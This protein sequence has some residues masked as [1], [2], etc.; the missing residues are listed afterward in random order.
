MAD[1]DDE[2]PSD[3]E[4]QRS[5][6]RHKGMALKA[7]PATA[8]PKRALTKAES[9]NLVDALFQIS[10]GVF[11]VWQALEA[12][13]SGKEAELQEQ[14]G[15]IEETMKEFERRVIDFANALDDSF[16]FE[17]PEEHG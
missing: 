7:L 10:G 13:R 11:S 1:E 4:I 14:L 8:L 6:E 3:A 16:L 2:G 9:D 17:D 15:I 5:I 12:I